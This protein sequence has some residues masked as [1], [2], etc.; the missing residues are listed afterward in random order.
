[1][2]AE[3]HIS[4]Q[5]EL[6]SVGRPWPPY[7]TRAGQRVPA[8]LGPGAIGLLEAARRRDRAV[9]ERQTLEIAAAVE[10][11]ELLVRELARLLEDRLDEIEREIAVQPLGDRAVEAGDVAHGEDHLA[12]RRAIAHRDSPD[13][14]RRAPRH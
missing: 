4:T 6:R 11:R 3:F 5:A 12:D 13:I 10:R 14:C 7:S 8:G 9:L 1:M 2:Q